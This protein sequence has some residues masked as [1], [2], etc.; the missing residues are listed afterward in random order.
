MDT[1]A[2]ILMNRYHWEI[3][4]NKKSNVDIRNIRYTI[5]RKNL[6]KYFKVCMFP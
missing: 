4:G 5:M 6:I 1:D 2:T 3:S